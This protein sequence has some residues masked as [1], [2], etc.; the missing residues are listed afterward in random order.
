MRHTRGALMEGWMYYNRMYNDIAVFWS[1]VRFPWHSSYNWTHFYILTVF[2]R[3]ETRA[4]FD[5]VSKAFRDFFGFTLQ[6][7]IC[8]NHPVRTK[9]KPMI[10]RSRLAL[11]AGICFDSYTVSALRTSTVIGYCD[12]FES[13]TFTTLY[14][15]QRQY[16]SSKYITTVFNEK[17]VWAKPLRSKPNQSTNGYFIRAMEEST[18][19]DQITVKVEADPY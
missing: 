2:S 9:L 18:F 15:K 12:C 16:I 11:L 10:T 3:T 1:A 5:S 19:H 4:T 14:I 7:V 17:M 8:L 6:N 13:S